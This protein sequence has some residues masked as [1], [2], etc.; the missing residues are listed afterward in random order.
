MFNA[1]ID[2]FNVFKVDPQM[3][4]TFLFLILVFYKHEIKE[5]INTKILKK[6]SKMSKSKFLDIMSDLRYIHEFH[7]EV[8]AVDSDDFKKELLN[9]INVCREE[10]RQ[11][12]LNLSK[13]QRINDYTR[14]AF[15]DAIIDSINKDNVNLLIIFPQENCTLLYDEIEQYINKKG[16][17]C[18]KIKRDLRQDDREIQDY[19][20]LE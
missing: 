12:I 19:C 6:K 3:G 17:S 5:F 9:A 16:S 7:K 8:I 2:F 13:I 14:E 18:V 11:L 1:I 20:G 4:V 15:R 10:R